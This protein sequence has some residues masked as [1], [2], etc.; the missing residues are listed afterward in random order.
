MDAGTAEL[1][2]SDQSMMGS[3]AMESFNKDAHQY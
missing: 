3:R 1:P 2:G